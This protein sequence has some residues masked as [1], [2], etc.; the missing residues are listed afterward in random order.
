M[1]FNKKNKDLP[2]VIIGGNGFVGSKVANL[3]NTENSQI[4]TPSK[5]QCD[6]TNIKSLNKFF[7]SN[8]TSIII[9]FAAFTNIEAAE[10]QRGDKN[11][12]AWKMNVEAVKKIAIISNKLDSF[13]IH[14]STDSVFP[15]TK[16][17]PGPYKENVIPPKNTKL[18]SWYSYT[19]LVGEDV[20]ID[21]ASNFAIIRISYP[22]GNSKSPKDFLVKTIKYIK[23]NTGFFYDQY[24]T[25]TYMPDLAKA[26]EI[27]INSKRKGVYHVI[28]TGITTPYKFALYTSKKLGLKDKIR[29]SKI[30]DYLKKP[31]SQMRA[32]YGGL[33]AYKT[34][35][36]LN[37]KFH[38]WQKA[39]D[40]SIN[41]IQ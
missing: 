23:H 28:C 2:L 38:T 6:I 8:D 17:F 1:Q 25:L 18:L 32:K 27:I 4:V 5:N 26:L 15:G 11:A 33:N 3:L 36:I 37:V 29:I 21:S 24:F 35:E 39:I 22:F 40:K 34:Q 41:E 13:Y 12:L 19:K 20:L 10:K 7:L 31:N 16:E 9:N 14:I 30:A